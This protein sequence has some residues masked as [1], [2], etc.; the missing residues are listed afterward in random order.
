MTVQLL[1]VAGIG[2]IT[3]GANLG[4]VI[5]EGLA[6]SGITLEERDIVVVT[7]K[8]VSKAEGAVARLT[9]DDPQAHRRL[10]EREAT[11]ILRRRGALTIA[12]TRHGFI[13]A[14]AG[15]DRSNV[16]PGSAVLL[17]LDP[18]RSAH[19]LRLILERASGVRLA[20]VITDT[21]GRPWRR[22]LTD[23]AI[24]VSGMPA[25]LDLRGTTDTWGRPLEVTEVAL[26]DE[27]AAAA[28]LVMGK[29]R[30]I[31]V[32]VI[33]GVEVRWGEGRG[34]DLVRLPEEDL[35]R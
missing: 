3:P 24:G 8:V 11:A 4:A 21:F 31:P 7:H 10:V 9:D 28:N 18:D 2:E 23:V 33:R 29:A 27:V 26:A 5:L 22:G 34:A 12:E 6:T 25:I 32:V 19:R 16:A 17:P 1:P 35:F 15:V 30:N 14:N 13:C 20:V